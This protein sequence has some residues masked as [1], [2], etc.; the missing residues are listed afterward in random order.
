MHD[1]ID[2]LRRFIERVWNNEDLAAVDEFV[3]D[4]YTIHSDPGDPWDGQTLS[5]DGFRERLAISR[6]P[7]PD[8]RFELGE[9]VAGRDCVAL[10]W[11]MRG[12]QT[13]VMGGRPPTNL[14][15]RVSGMTFYYFAAGLLTGHRQVVDRLAV[16]Q[17]LGLLGG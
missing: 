9:M 16:A 6:A 11:I 10:W 17:Q 5:R 14:P 4:A 1:N 15:I 8:L 2:V 13:G 3:A 7:F 12:T